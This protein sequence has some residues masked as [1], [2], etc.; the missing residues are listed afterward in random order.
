MA[1]S[2]SAPPHIPP[3]LDSGAITLARGV[4]RTDAEVLRYVLQRTRYKLFL[5][6]EDY[7]QA[8]ID[9][10]I[11][12]ALDRLPQLVAFCFRSPDPLG[13]SHMFICAAGLGIG[14]YAT[15]LL[16]SRAR[17]PL[18]FCRGNGERKR[19]FMTTKEARQ[20]LSDLLV[21]RFDSFPLGHRVA[22]LLIALCSANNNITMAP[23]PPPPAKATAAA[24]SQPPPGS[25]GKPDDAEDE[26][27]KQ[28]QDRLIRAVHDLVDMQVQRQLESILATMPPPM[29]PDEPAWDL[30]ADAESFRQQLLLHQVVDIIVRT[31]THTMLV[32]LGYAP[33]PA[34]SAKP[35]NK[36]EEGKALLPRLFYKVAQILSRRRD[37]R[38]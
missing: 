29:G 8:L 36:V 34:V 1:G 13:P 2:R 4:M 7:Q 37:G 9:A 5:T 22:S 10:D 15:H 30:R 19:T 38:Q 28:F 24:A 32:R 21:E 11:D 35:D 16:L 3:I 26:D 14:V 33:K 6:G 17:I 12:A 27:R 20:T 31:L 23:P 25:S 18:S